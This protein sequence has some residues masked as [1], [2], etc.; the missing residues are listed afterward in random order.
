MSG[1]ASSDGSERSE[2]STTSTPRNVRIGCQTGLSAVVAETMPF[3]LRGPRP[4]GMADHGNNMYICPVA[5]DL[6]KNI[7]EDVDPPQFL[8]AIVK[9]STTPGDCFTPV[10]FDSVE[11]TSIQEQSVREGMAHCASAAKFL[12]TYGVSAALPPQPKS[13]IKKK[14]FYIGIPC[15]TETPVSFSSHLLF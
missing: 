12:R 15:F 4:E 8:D 10:N 5:T 6:F 3:I 2:H 9:A 7:Y 13:E 1:E 14:T 11:N